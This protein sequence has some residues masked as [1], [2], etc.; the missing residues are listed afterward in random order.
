M[1]IFISWSGPRSQYVAEALRLWLKDVMQQLDPWVS[2][3]DIRQGSRWNI[4]V[5]KKLEEASFGILCLTRDNLTEPWILFEAGALA[6]TL[7]Q[8]HVCPYL[9]DLKPSDLRGPLVQFQCA[10]ATESDTRKL[11]HS[12]NKAMGEKALPEDQVD[13]ACRKWWPDLD[14]ALHRVPKPRSALPEPRS[15]RE[16]LEELLDRVRRIDISTQKEIG[17]SMGPPQSQFELPR[18]LFNLFE[19][20]DVLALLGRVDSLGTKEDQNAIPWSQSDLDVPGDELDGLW[21]TRWNGGSALERWISGVARVQ[22]YGEY[23]YAI[24]H[25]GQADCFIATRR[26]DGHRLAGRYINL[27]AP[28]EVLAWA[29]RIIDNNRIDGYWMQGR[30]DLRR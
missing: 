29:G 20:E 19:G 30:W 12:I 25:D 17:S 15:E 9:I 16:L 28:R 23:L 3:E 14:A 11:I 4:D 5:A 13:R 8:S 26:L 22:V 21:S 18:N 10:Q 2:S 24:T 6:K 7:A 1:L 27:G